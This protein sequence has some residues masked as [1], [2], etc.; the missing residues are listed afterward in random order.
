MLFPL[1]NGGHEALEDAWVLATSQHHECTAVF[2]CHCARGG[3]SKDPPVPFTQEALFPVGRPVE[4]GRIMARKQRTR[5][6]CCDLFAEVISGAAAKRVCR[7][8]SLQSAYTVLGRTAMQTIP[9]VYDGQAIRPLERFRARPNT[10]VIITFLEDEG[11]ESA[12]P[13]TRIEEVAGCLAF[14]GPAKTIE[15][16]NAA[17]L[18]HAKEQRR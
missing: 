17:V 5:P 11:R 4:T 3:A 12:F 2:L 14:S 18:R 8:L 15:E 6:E 10:R 13:P 7:P 1:M 16:M 9:G